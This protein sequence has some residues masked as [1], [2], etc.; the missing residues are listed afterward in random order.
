MSWVQSYAQ[1]LLAVPK[2]NF[3]EP[4]PSVLLSNLTASRLLFQATSSQARPNWFKAFVVVQLVDLP[5]VAAAPV[6]ALRQVI[7]LNQPLLIEPISSPSYSLRFEIPY[8]MPEITIQ[9]W[10]GE[11]VAGDAPLR[12]TAETVTG[13][14]R[15]QALYLLPS[16]QA[17]LAQANTL[18]TGAI[19]GFAAS[20][21]AVGV[22]VPYFTEGVLEL[23]DWSLVAGS[24]FLSPG[25]AYFL[26]PDQPGQITVNAPTETGCV[27]VRVGTALSST[28]LDIEIQQAFLL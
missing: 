5:G 13:I 24:Q 12:N 22:A 20:S 21:V 3:H 14:E 8:Y 6:E 1:T 7:P 23:P 27:V 17:D 4:I 15:G 19:V 18:T 28:A 25:R 16:G 10:E 11:R 26:S 2:G 9:M